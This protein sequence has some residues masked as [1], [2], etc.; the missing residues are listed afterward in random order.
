MG[1]STD[2]RGLKGLGF[3]PV[4]AGQTQG[5]DGN[6]DGRKAR[7]AGSEESQHVLLVIN[8]SSRAFSR[9]GLTSCTTL[10]Q[11]SSRIF[12]ATRGLQLAS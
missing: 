3:W 4:R 7:A 8:S 12:S 11:G 5:R 9:N 1:Q 10:S 2:S 6:L